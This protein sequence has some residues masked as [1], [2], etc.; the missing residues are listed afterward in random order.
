MFAHIRRRV[1]GRVAGIMALT[2]LLPVLSGCM[3]PKEMRKEN[4]AT[5]AESIL[6][7][8][9]AVDR[10]KEK[11]GVLP[12]KNSEAETP[13]YEKYVLD[14]KKLTQGPYLGQ[15]PG[16]AFEK[17]GSF[18]FVLVNPEQK[19]EVKLMD[20]TGYQKAGDIQKWV[21]EYRKANNGAI[22]Q[23]EPAGQDVYRLD[24][25]KLGKKT[26][27]SE[28]VYSRTYLSYLV[29]SNGTVAIDYAPE[30]MKAMER[31]G[32]KTAQADL[33]LRSLLVS[34]APYVPV[35]S[36]PYYWTDNEPKASAR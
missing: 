14:L 35:K 17:G 26:A 10:Y 31:K 8:Q 9:N 3:Y 7:V 34:E 28:S 16:I 4:Q 1:S 19:P 18:L 29:S 23:G 32:M 22:P 30:I 20:I 24:F 11:N 12:I 15:V 2:V 5:A 21:D 33:D 36:F 13:I 27:Q 25:A 6:V